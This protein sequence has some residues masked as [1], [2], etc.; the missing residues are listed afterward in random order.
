MLKKTIIFIVR[1]CKSISRICLLPLALIVVNTNCVL[2]QELH[3]D[4][5]MPLYPGGNAALK[6][7]IVKNLK[8]PDAAIKAGISGSVLVNFTID[9]NGKVQNIKVM[10]GLS[11]EC[12]AEA[13]RLTGLLKGWEPGKRQGKPVNITVAMPVEFKSDKKLS[14]ATISGKVTE[15]TT[16]KAIEGAF[17]IIKGTN[18]GSVT[19]AEGSYRIDLPAESHD[20]IIFSVGYS[21]EEIPI[22][23]H[24][25]INIEL[26]TE[27]HMIDFTTEK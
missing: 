20:L 10:Q 5:L 23:Y 21:S 9:Q 26:E 14:P 25:T 11:P 18:V 27:H 24:S 2:A 16:G 4:N 13:I 6:E 8:Y 3:A 7:T 22:D 12:D 15:K 1:N 19:N 17:V